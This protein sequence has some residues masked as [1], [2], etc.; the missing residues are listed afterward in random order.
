MFWR[1]TYFKPLTLKTVTDGTS[2]T[3][4]VG[5]NVV[6]Q[7]F[8]SAAYFADG[9]WATCGMPLN[10]FIIPNPTL[11]TRQDTWQEARG[12]RSYHPGGAQFVF[13]DG[14]V[15]FLAESIDHNEYRA[16]CTRNQGDSAATIAEDNND[17]L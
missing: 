15:Q 4:M 14:A 6:E 10:H 17:D 1:N 2:K 12:F 3:I 8:H 9:D 7:D 11:A 5:E 13:A 16:M